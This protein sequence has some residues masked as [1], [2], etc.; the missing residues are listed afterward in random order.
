MSTK[1]AMTT[2]TDA[3]RERLALVAHFGTDWSYDDSDDG[4]TVSYAT[5]HPQA[6]HLATVA[7]YGEHVAD[8]IAHAPRDLAALLAEVD[9]LR[10]VL[11]SITANESV[12][13]AKADLADGML[14][15]LR[16]TA[17]PTT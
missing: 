5:D 7:D 14:A 6:G 8:L 15:A 4:W 1:S 11:D 9:R 12:V 16:A 10:G 2:D 13:V 3:I 17:T